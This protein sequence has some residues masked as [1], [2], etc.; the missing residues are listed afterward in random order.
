MQAADLTGWL[1]SP[2]TKLLLAYLHRRKA[3]VLQTFLQGQPVDQAAQGRAAAWHEL[4]IL[5]ALPSD[6]VKRIFETAPKE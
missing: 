4:E 2:E 3:G 1:N 5:L 6:E